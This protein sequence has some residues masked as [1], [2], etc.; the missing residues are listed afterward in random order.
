MTVNRD[1]V[2]EALGKLD[3]D[4]ALRNL[5]VRE[6]GYEHEGGLISGDGWPEDLAGDPMLFASTAKDGRFTVIRARLSKRGKLSLVTERK[7]MEQLRQRYPYAL[8]T[9]SDA[10]DRLWHFVNAPHGAVSPTSGAEDGCM[11]YRRI[12]VGLGEGFRT[13]T[14][15]ISILSVDDLVERTSKEADELSPLEVQA[16]HDEAF[17]VEAVTKEFFREYRRV[18]ESVER[19]ITGIEDEERRR[20]FVQRLFNRLMFVAFVQKKGWLSLNRRTDYLAALWEA[21]VA[22]TDER[23]LSFYRSNLKLLFFRGFN[24]EDA[25][26]TEDSVIGTVPYLNGGLFEEDEDDKDELIDVPDGCLDEIRVGNA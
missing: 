10:E 24:K 20:Y 4:R 17:D 7:V 21:Y 23:T 15:R 9:F 3:G 8:Y 2:H 22:S 11:Q 1:K 16:A 19:S 13:A 26:G 14:E 6:L 18:F 12:V 5:L 25:P